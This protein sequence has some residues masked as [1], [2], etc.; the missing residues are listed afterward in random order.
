MDILERLFRNKTRD[1]DHLVRN[2]MYLFPVWSHSCIAASQ[3]LPFLPPNA[4]CIRETGMVQCTSIPACLPSLVGPV[5]FGYHPPRHNPVWLW[6]CHTTTPTCKNKMMLSNEILPF[7]VQSGGRR[8]GSWCYYRCLHLGR[9]RRYGFDGAFVEVTRHP[10]WAV[11][12]KGS[13]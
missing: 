7:L 8:G 2:I 12:W 9:R 4:C 5:C 3:A 11:H 1:H 13:K 6:S 10:C